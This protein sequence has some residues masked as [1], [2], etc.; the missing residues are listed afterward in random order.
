MDVS[1]PETPPATA[2]DVGVM[3]LLQLL[4]ELRMGLGLD[5]DGSDTPVRA[6]GVAGEYGELSRV[7]SA[8][9]L[10][11]D[12]LASVSND[13]LRRRLRASAPI[14]ARLARLDRR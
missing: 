13:T 5:P 9:G 1:E 3:V 11:W 2:A 6:R 12:P 8:P 14:I 10:P 7:I 4:T